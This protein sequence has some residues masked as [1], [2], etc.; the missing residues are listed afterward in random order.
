MANVEAYIDFSETDNIENFVLEN[1][2]INLEKLAKEIKV[3]WL[4]YEIVELK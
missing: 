2:K 1:V 4:F 3:C